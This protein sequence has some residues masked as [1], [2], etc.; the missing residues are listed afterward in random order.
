MSWRPCSDSR[1]FSLSTTPELIF[2]DV[3][4]SQFVNNLPSKTAPD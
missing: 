3:A 1:W 2:P 4:A